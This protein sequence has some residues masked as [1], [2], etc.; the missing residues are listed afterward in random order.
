MLPVGV[1]LDAALIAP[2]GLIVGDAAIAAPEDEAGRPASATNRTDARRPQPAVIAQPLEQSIAAQ[3][4]ER[5]GDADVV[6]DGPIGSESRAIVA[7]VELGVADVEVHLAN[8]GVILPFTS[9][10][11]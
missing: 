8:G 7:V 11:P 9:G 2:L 1:E 5:I 3:L 4:I 10:V 6:G